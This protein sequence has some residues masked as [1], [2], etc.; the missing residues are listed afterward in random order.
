LLECAGTNKVA[1]T[2]TQP[3]KVTIISIGAV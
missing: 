3:F 2:R 1:V